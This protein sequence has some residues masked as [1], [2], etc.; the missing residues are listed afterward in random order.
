LC[1]EIRPNDSRGGSALPLP[2]AGKAIAYV[3]LVA[4]NVLSLMVRDAP[5]AALLT[6]RVEDFAANKTSS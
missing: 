6:M 4:V 5:Q 2:L 3:S 1:E